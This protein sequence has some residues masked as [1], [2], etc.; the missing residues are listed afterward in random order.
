MLCNACNDVFAGKSARTVSPLKIRIHHYTLQSFQASVSAGCHMCS[1]ISASDGFLPESASPDYDDRMK[2][3][4]IEW[5]FLDDELLFI[6]RKY[7]EY[8]HAS[9]SRDSQAIFK[10]IKAE[11]AAHAASTYV[12]TPTTLSD[13]ALSVAKKWYEECLEEHCNACTEASKGRHRFFPSRIVDVGELADPDVRVIVPP[14]PIDEPYAT[15]SHCWGHSQTLRLVQDNIEGFARGIPLKTLPKTFEEAVIVARRLD[16]RYLWIDSL[17]ILQDS[18][19]D[20]RHESAQ[21]R[22]IYLHGALNIAATS[23]TS[24]AAGL[25]SRRH[26]ARTRHLRVTITWSPY[27][28]PDLAAHAPPGPYYL[29]AADLW[30]REVEAG[31][32]NARG[33]VLQER[34]LAPRILHFGRSQLYWQCNAAFR[35]EM[36]A[37]GVGDEEG[38]LGPRASRVTSDFVMCLR[39]REEGEG[40]QRRKEEAYARWS[41]LVNAYSATALTRAEDKLIAVQA[42]AETMMAATGDASS[43]SCKIVIDEWDEKTAHASEYR[44]SAG[45]LFFPVGSPIAGTVEGLILEPVAQTKGHFRRTAY[46]EVDIASGIADDILEGSGCLGHADNLNQLKDGEDVQGRQMYRFTLI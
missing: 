7:S 12:Q 5:L 34:A 14:I 26:P 1:L 13:S 17:C 23:A 38:G 22:N 25:S 41:E 31:P 9:T 21:M 46:F 18:P 37:G 15:L 30:D 27:T 42:L 45:T 20:W 39:E 24:D 28:Q 35:E 43:W 32:L 40:R 16:L 6:E 4:R 19:E 3:S 36:F 2:H 8:G 29:S 44:L 11:G 33:W 10:L